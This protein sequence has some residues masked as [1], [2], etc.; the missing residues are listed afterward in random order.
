MAH[1]KYAPCIKACYDCAA[2]CDHCATACLAEQ[3][4]GM[5]ARCIA[6]DMDCA[7]CVG[8]LPQL[9]LEIAS[10][11]NGSA[12][13]ALRSAPRVLT[14]VHAIPMGI[15]R[16]VPA[17]VDIAQKNAEKWRHKPKLPVR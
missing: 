2:A 17:S 1:D 8:L 4:V 11:L 5:M 14:S 9:W 12:H 6:L 13:F 15:V 7:R 10:W 3:D 16:N